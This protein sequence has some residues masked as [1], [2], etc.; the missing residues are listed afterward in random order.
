MAEQVSAVRKRQRSLLLLIPVL[1]VV[2]VAV[3]FATITEVA[4]GERTLKGVVYGVSKQ[5]GADMAGFK[6]PDSVGAEDAK[7]K[8]EIFLRG[9][10]GCHAMTAIKGEALGHVVD[11]QRVR[12]VFRDTAQA[13]ALKRFQEVKL[14]C[15][16][17]IAVNGKVKFELPAPG[18]K[19]K[20]RVVYLT[21]DHAGMHASSPAR[22]AVSPK[23]DAEAG[24]KVPAERPQM[25]MPKG[26]MPAA[27]A[28]PVDPM[29]DLGSVLDQ[30]LKRQ[31]DGKGLGLTPAEFSTRLL[32]E[33]KTV[34]DRLKTEAELKAKEQEK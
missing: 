33:M 4:R 7:V 28:A 22:P 13:E 9:G 10:D 34:E 2:A 11:P 26:A 25:P 15:D 31:Y 16:Q 18:G 17:G 6:V 23:S 19:G 21:G 1:L 24:G 20:K 8:V 5:S 3:N 29:A 27:S 30:E 12:I 32:A 14:G